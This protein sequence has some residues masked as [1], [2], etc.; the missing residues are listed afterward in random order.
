MSSKT[1]T[2]RISGRTCFQK[3]WSVFHLNQQYDIIKKPLLS[4]EF[5]FDSDPS[6]WEFSEETNHNE[7]NLLTC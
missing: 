3:F 5:C 1:F 7:S 2:E 4:P 6:Y